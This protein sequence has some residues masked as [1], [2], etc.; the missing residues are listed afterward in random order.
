MAYVRRRYCSS[1][2][3]NEG[4]KWKGSDAPRGMVSIDGVQVPS[5]VGVG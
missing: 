1:K 2:F 4:S 5:V 3:K